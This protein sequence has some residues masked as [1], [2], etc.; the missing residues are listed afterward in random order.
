[1]LTPEEQKKYNA[2]KV[3]E[4]KLSENPK[5]I[6]CPGVLRKVRRFIFKMEAKM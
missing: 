6:K 5:D 2:A 4:A 3:R 1:M